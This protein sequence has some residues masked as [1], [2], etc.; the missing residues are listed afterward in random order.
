MLGKLF[1]G[2]LLTP[3]T[4]FS[5]TWLQRTASAAQLN[6]ARIP[7]STYFSVCKASSSTPISQ[8]A[9]TGYRCPPKEILEIVETPPEPLYSF[10][11]D[12]TMV[13]QLSRPPSNPPIS[14]FARAELK[15]AGMWSFSVVSSVSP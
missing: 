10:S 7:P 13:L 2:R 5:S 14:E 3:S 1:P 9:S 11:P 12:R 8:N 4:L 15:L 6:R